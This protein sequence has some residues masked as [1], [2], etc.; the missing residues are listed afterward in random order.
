[1][2]KEYTYELLRF[3]FKNTHSNVVRIIYTIDNVM[4][5]RQL[6][7]RSPMLWEDEETIGVTIWDGTDPS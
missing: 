2:C 3:F 5:V 1:M 7:C 6:S 4:V